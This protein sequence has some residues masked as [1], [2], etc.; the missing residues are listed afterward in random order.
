M[1]NEE[2]KKLSDRIAAELTERRIKEKNALLKIL[3]DTV[4]R[5]YDI[6]PDFYMSGSIRTDCCN[7][8][9]EIDLFDLLRDY[10]DI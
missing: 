1:T 4:K 6:D 3:S 9:M 2:L 8:L 7:E 5:L 10:F